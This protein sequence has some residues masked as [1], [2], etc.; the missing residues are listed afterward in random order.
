M[1]SLSFWVLLSRTHSLRWYTEE[2][3][4]FLWGEQVPGSLPPVGQA[5]LAVS[6]ALSPLSTS[7]SDPPSRVVVRPSTRCGA[8][9]CNCALNL[10]TWGDWDLGR[11]SWRT[12]EVSG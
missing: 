9:L 2:L 3:W 8:V 11:G 1:H 12:R 7:A 4:G 10:G 6:E 5:L